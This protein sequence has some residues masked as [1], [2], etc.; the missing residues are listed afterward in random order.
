MSGLFIKNNGRIVYQ[1]RAGKKCIGILKPGK[2]S[3]YFIFKGSETEIG[4]TMLAKE[5]IVKA[6]LKMISPLFLNHLV[7]SQKPNAAS[8]HAIRLIPINVVVFNT[9]EKSASVAKK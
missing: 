6:K 2:S 5:R 7:K 3:G 4:I 8:K 1:A 9:F